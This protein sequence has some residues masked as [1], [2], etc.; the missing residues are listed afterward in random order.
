MVVGEKKIVWI[1]SAFS[2]DGIDPIERVA[3]SYVSFVEQQGHIPII[4]PHVQSVWPYYLNMCDAFVFIGS[5][6]DID[7]HLYG[8]KNT[9]SKNVQTTYDS[10]ELAFLSEIQKTKKPL[11]GICRWMQLINIYFG[12]TLHQDIENHMFHEEQ[13]E[14]VHSVTIQNSRRIPDGDYKINSIHH[15]AVD[16]VGDGLV[17]TGRAPDGTIEMIE[18]DSLPWTWVQWHPEFFLP[19]NEWLHL[20]PI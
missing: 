11:L 6:W 1:Q 8:Q 17:V 4:L 3:M 9:T 19:E 12:G 13:E 2:Q 18:H 14:A 7:P 20:L 5:C 16:V 15:Q 10:Y